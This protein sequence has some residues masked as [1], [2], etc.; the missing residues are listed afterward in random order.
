VKWRYIDILDLTVVF[1]NTEQAQGLKLVE[2]FFHASP[3]KIINVH[4]V[5]L[6]Y[7]YH[8]SSHCLRESSLLFPVC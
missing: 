4:K 2:I 7:K 1:V 8:P 3:V 6:L 5:P